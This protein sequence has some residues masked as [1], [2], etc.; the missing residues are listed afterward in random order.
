MPLQL[1]AHHTA[2]HSNAAA[3]EPTASR[4]IADSRNS[5]MDIFGEG[6]A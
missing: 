2:I 5:D 4:S 6:C 3:A 1:T